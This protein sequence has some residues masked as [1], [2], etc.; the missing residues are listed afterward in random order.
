MRNGGEGEGEGLLANIE[1]LDHAQAVM[2]IARSDTLSMHH[3]PKFA[4]ITRYAALNACS[5][6]AIK[7]STCSI[8]MDKR[9]I[10]SDTPAFANSSGFN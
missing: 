5:K 6:S 2:L 1:T 10:S 8:P 7:S 3:F 9:S 4:A